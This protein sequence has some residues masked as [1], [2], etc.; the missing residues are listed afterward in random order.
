MNDRNTI[1]FH[2]Y[3]WDTEE[4]SNLSVTGK[5][6]VLNPDRKE[7]KTIQVYVYILHICMGDPDSGRRRA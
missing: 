3:G 6:P 4:S 5:V 7:I 1:E 2:P